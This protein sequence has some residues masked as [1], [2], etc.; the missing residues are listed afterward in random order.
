MYFRENG[1]SSFLKKS[2]K[3]VQKSRF[4]RVPFSTTLAPEGTEKYHF[5]MFIFFSARTGGNGIFELEKLRIMVC[6][7]EKRITI[8]LPEPLPT[9]FWKQYSIF[10]YSLCTF[11]QFRDEKPTGFDQR[12]RSA[13]GGAKR[14]Q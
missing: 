14:Q 9:S 7:S 12:R 5:S 6:L 8:W 10:I 13:E 11:I 2:E 4:K 3:H 1:T